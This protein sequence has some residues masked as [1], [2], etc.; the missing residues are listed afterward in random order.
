MSFVIVSL[1]AFV[2]AFVGSLPLAGPIALLVVSN[3]ASGRY[4]DARRI[5]FGAAVAEGIYAFL[6]FW[7]FATFLAR[8]ALV[9]PISHGITA[10]VLC[11]LGTHFLFFTLKARSTKLHDES[12]SGR[13]WV[14]LS[15]AAVNP[16]LIVTWGA[17]TTFLYSKQLVQ[18]TALLAIPFGCCAAAGIAVWGV[19]V[20]AL[21]ERFG[22]GVPRLTLT[23]IVRSMGVIMIGVGLWSGVALG[24]YVLERRVHSEKGGAA[25]MDAGPGSQT[26]RAS[27]S[28]VPRCHVPSPSRPMFRGRPSLPTVP[29]TLRG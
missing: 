12:D 8:H 5:A 17:V 14:G 7:G 22:R 25:T 27:R 13:F 15:I 1:V 9:L 21:L 20:V 26:C 2:F 4:K 16:T 11:G 24:R 28:E 18:F 29:R 10:V 6:A 3:G 19:A 23:W